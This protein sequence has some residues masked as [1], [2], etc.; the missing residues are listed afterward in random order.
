MITIVLAVVLFI[1][2]A[3]AA[4]VLLPFVLVGARS[5]VTERHHERESLSDYLEIK[6]VDRAGVPES[7][8]PLAPSAPA[9]SQ[10]RHRQ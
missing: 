2:A 4:A 8:S 6:G 1:I 7:P 3:S 5:A 10:I 9:A